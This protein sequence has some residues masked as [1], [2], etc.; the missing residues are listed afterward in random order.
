MLDDLGEIADELAEHGDDA[1]E[2]FDVDVLYFADEG[3]RGIEFCAELVGG[4]RL[5]ALGGSAHG[6]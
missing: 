5:L 4:V 6:K 2:I 1:F 3:K